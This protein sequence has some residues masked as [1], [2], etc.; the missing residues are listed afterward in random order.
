MPIAGQLPTDWGLQLWEYIDVTYGAMAQNGLLRS[1]QGSEWSNFKMTD[2]GID[3]ETLR[4]FY[5][6]LLRK[7]RERQNPYP[8]ID[9]WTKFMESITF[10]RLVK[11]EATKQLH[12]PTYLNALHSSSETEVNVQSMEGFI[13]CIRV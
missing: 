10:P 1:T 2:V 9:V 4:R 6:E 8:A 12:N 5:A 11:D 13:P 7:N 3:K